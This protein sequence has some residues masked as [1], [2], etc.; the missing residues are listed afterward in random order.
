ML[1]DT[2]GMRELQ[3]W[4]ADD[5]LSRTFQDVEALAEGC[6]FRDCAHDGEPGCAVLEAVRS[7][8]LDGARLESYLKLASELARVSGDARERAAKKG[9]D[10]SMQRA[11][12]ARLREKGRGD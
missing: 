5:G 10:K 3:L 1:M 9:F 6:R 2:P 7:G 12:R 11:L 8:A 4:G